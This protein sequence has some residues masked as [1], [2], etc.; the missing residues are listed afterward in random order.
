MYMV[1][2]RDQ[3]AGR[4]HNTKTDNSSFK[5]EKEFTYLGSN[6]KNQNST[7]EEIKSRLKSG[8]VALIRSSI[9]YLPVCNPKIQ[10]SKYTELQF[11]LF[12]VWV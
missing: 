1:M 8:N 9:F 6:L 3:D 4:S 11:Y 10:R 2:S 12:F 5:K 7:Q